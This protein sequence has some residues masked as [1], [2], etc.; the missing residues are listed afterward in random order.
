MTPLPDSVT[1]IESVRA[2][3]AAAHVMTEGPGPASFC[4]ARIGAFRP[5]VAAARHHEARERF[6]SG[7]LINT[8]QR[9]RPFD[10]AIRH[11]PRRSHHDDWREP[12]MLAS[13]RL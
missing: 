3:A 11:D 12:A 1:R 5:M 7:V 9:S 10:A 4:A 13:A 8:R 2:R 6:A